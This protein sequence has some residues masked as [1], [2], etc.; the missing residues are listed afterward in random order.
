[1]K[2]TELLEDPGAHREPFFIFRPHILQKAVRYFQSHFDGKV[3]YAIKTNPEPHIIQQ[4]HALGVHSFELASLPEIELVKSL[5][6]DC[7]CFFMNPVKSRQAIR[8]AYFTYGVRHFSLDSEAELKKIM[9]ETENAKDLAL[10]V[11]LS[12]PNTYAEHSLADKFGINMINAP[13]LLKATRQAAEK[14]GVCFHVGSQCM[15]PDAYRI[16]IRM[17]RDL[18]RPLRFSIDSLNVGGGFPSIYPGLIPPP[19]EHYF[20]AIRQEFSIMNR[21]RNLKLYCEPGR[22]LVAESTSLIIQVLLRKN[23]ALY[24]NDGIYGA[25]FDAGFPKLI[26]PVQHIKPRE[27]E[28]NS[29]TA[30]RFYGPTCDSLDQMAGPFYLPNNIKEGDFIEVGQLGAYGRTLS[31]KFNGFTQRK[32]VFNVDD[33]PLMTLYDTSAISREPLEVIAA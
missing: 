22:A 2:L 25:M 23:D 8:E 1:M 6:P 33:E 5:F 20:T 30:Y 12:I 14:L 27:S 28:D 17:T 13:T 3:L 26:Y 4:V 16:A 15:H 29:L 11:R 9:E 24:I 19:L 18:L 21:N 10:H 31:T 7:E 32:D